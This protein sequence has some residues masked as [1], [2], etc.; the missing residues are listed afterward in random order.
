MGTSPELIFFP[1]T[2]FCSI[3]FFSLTGSNA[4]PNFGLV[5]QNNILSVIVLSFSYREA[6]SLSINFL[7]LG[8]ALSVS[9]NWSK[10]LSTTIFQIF[11]TSF[12][13]ITIQNT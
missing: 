11:F 13:S 2:W 12:V 8:L 7:I 3:R 5:A 6:V 10:Q 4:V 9:N 1:N